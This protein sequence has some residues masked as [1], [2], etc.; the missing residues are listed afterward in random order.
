MLADESKYE[1]VE[2]KNL[3]EF[4]SM[5]INY[6]PVVKMKRLPF[7]DVDMYDLML[8]AGAFEEEEYA[9]EC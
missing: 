8:A 9:E 1:F 2:N 5:W 6:F 4:D 3:F 7:Y